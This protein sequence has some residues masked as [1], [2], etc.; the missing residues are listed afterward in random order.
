MILLRDNAMQK[1]VEDAERSYPN[2]ACGLLLGERQ[3]PDVHVASVHVSG[4][5]SRTPNSF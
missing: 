1:I 3:G 5:L 2:E 4:N